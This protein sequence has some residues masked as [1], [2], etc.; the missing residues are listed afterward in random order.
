MPN[1]AFTV[2]DAKAQTI[3]SIKTIQNESERSIRSINLP[4]F[5]LQRQRT[6]RKVQQEQLASS[7]RIELYMRWLVPSR[8]ASLRVARCA[9]PRCRLPVVR[10]QGGRRRV[11]W[12]VRQPALLTLNGNLARSAHSSLQHLSAQIQHAA[13][14]DARH[15]ALRSAETHN[16]AS[17]ATRSPTCVP[18]R[19]DRRSEKRDLG[20]SVLRDQIGSGMRS[21]RLS[22]G[23]GPPR[24]DTTSCVVGIAIG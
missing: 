5:N 3:S 4:C 23:V 18:R 19:R 16:T 8:P 17:R 21:L 15:A 2:G 1:L 24:H 10:L 20:L 9:V 22:C 12:P 13:I 11:R 14:E 7:S 6:V